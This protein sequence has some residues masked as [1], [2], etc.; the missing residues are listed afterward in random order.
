MLRHVKRLQIDSRHMSALRWGTVVLLYKKAQPQVCP[1]G[2][3]ASRTVTNEN[4]F[5]QVKPSV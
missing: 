2:K 4:L 1:Q 5:T 3:V